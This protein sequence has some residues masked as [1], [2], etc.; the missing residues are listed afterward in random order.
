MFDMIV[1]SIKKSKYISY[2]HNHTAFYTEYNIF[3]QISKYS[4]IIENLN[5]IVYTKLIFLVF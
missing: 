2:V 3:I 4:S 1:K 5:F